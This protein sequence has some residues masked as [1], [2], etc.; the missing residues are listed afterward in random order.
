MQEIE[1]FG[2]MWQ[3]IDWSALKPLLYNYY[4]W[5]LAAVPFCVWIG[6]KVFNPKAVYETKS[7]NGEVTISVKSTVKNSV[8]MNITINPESI[9]VSEN[10]KD[11]KKIN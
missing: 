5:A 8:T 4:F 6:K 2:K 7:S 11:I 3:S 1:Q 9:K 10:Q